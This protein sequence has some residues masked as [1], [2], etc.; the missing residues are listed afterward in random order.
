[1]G[2]V[3]NWISARTIPE[4]LSVGS[5]VIAALAYRRAGRVRVLDR[6]TE[7]L[8]DI[9]DLR[10]RL[11]CLERSIPDAVQSRLNAS[12]ATGSALGGAAQA[13]KQDAGVD[14]VEIGVLRGRLEEMSRLPFFQTYA[15][16][17]ARMVSV[18]EVRTR[19]EV[20]SEK[21]AAA[22]RE[23]AATRL[24]VSQQRTALTAAGVGRP[25]PS[26]LFEEARRRNRSSD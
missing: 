22:A 14:T 23:D 9:A 10:P 26:P 24:Q 16:I 15:R 4:W 17:E 18:R 6:R 11:E 3:L 1:M 7:L 21:Y 25:D 5:L 8:K 13:F 19:F 2:V 12:S 20:L